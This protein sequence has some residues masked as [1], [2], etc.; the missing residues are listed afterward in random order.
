MSIF[1]GARVI[2]ENRWSRVYELSSG[3]RTYASKFL[4]DGL[5]VSS[6]TLITEWPTWSEHERLEFAKAYKAKPEI[7]EEDQQIL[8]FLIENGNE[9][10]WV[11]IA[12]ILVKHSDRE[13]VLRFLLARLDASSSEP[14]GNFMQALTTI[15][16]PRVA[17]ALKRFY[18]RLQREINQ[19][20]GTADPILTIDFLHCCSALMELERDSHYRGAIESY[21]Q[22]SRD[23]VR[24]AAIGV[25]NR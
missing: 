2:S 4:T 10:V 25:L 8:S 19:A 12:T 21:L 11:S 3:T 6:D 16:D 9:R 22:D 24:L 23:L 18:E 14:K 17:P 15:A 13:M 7:T 5:T 20:G 1:D